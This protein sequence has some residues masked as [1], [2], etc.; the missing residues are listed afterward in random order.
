MSE[1]D[2][3]VAEVAAELGLGD[4]DVPTKA[5]LD[6]A[7]DV[8][9][10]VLRPGAPVSAYLLGL[11][12]AAGADPADAAQRISALALRRAVPGN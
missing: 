1:L 12:V 7:R 11:A 4:V 10:N 2:E 3:W 9:H 5:V 6:V 8:A